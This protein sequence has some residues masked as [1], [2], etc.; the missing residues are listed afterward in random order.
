MSDSIGKIPPIGGPAQG[1]PVSAASRVTRPII[2]GRPS[3][4]HMPEAQPGK[5]FQELLET[6]LAQRST[7]SLTFSRHAQ[8]RV[9]QR[10][11][12]LSSDDM[13]RLSQAVEQAGQKGITDSLVFMNDTAFIVNIPNRVV[14]TV[15][16]SGD[17]EHNV[18]TNINGAVIV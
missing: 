1:S 8:Q 10:G 7:L 2:T 6:S 15:V 5:S 11:V 9:E 18:F 14:V 13:S 16:D 17:T 4:P 12:A 3:L